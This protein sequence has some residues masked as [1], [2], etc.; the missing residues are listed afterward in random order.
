MAEWSERR[1]ALDSLLGADLAGFNDL[2]REKGIPSVI[3]P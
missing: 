3:V 2:A 1:A